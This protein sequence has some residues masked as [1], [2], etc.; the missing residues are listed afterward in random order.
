MNLRHSRFT[1]TVAAGIAIALCTSLYLLVPPPTLRDWIKE[2]GF[3]EIGSA[4]IWFA[5]AAV[6]AA[7][8]AYRSPRALF[9]AS[10][11]ITFLFGARELD[12]HK[13]FTTDSLLKSNYY[14]KS[15]APLAEKLIAGVVVLA[16]ALVVGYVVV[17]YG[18][19]FLKRLASLYPPALTLAHALVLLVLTKLIDRSVNVLKD[20]W[21][22]AVPERLMHLQAA[23]EEPLEFFVPLIVLLAI[24]QYAGDA[25]RRT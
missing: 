14:L 18:M 3:F 15:S 8:S 22:L 6:L 20:D 7:L 11:V 13:A 10:A 19:R 21:Q 24:W 4:A 17:R 2:D 16:I 12:W 23:F 1:G 9:A 5:A 25:E